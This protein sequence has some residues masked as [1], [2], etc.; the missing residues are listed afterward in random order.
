MKTCNK[1]VFAGHERAVA[2]FES[3]AAVKACTR[4]V[5]DQARETSSMDRG[6]THE[7]P[8]VVEELL[9]NDGSWER[10]VVLQVVQAYRLRV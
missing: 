1:T 10:M 8:P 4:V 3:T 2:H 6:R 5:Q 7:V 9:A